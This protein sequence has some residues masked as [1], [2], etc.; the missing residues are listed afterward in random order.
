MHVSLC[1][2]QQTLY[3]TKQQISLK[4]TADQNGAAVILE[5][6]DKDKC[7]RYEHLGM[8]LDRV[9]N[10]GDRLHMYDLIRQ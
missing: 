3:N 2:S 10:C 5:T 6:D 8:T 9:R 4:E 1:L 7:E